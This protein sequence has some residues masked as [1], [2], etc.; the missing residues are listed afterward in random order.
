MFFPN[1]EH[2]EFCWNLENDRKMLK[3]S[4]TSHDNLEIKNEKKTNRTCKHNKIWV[5]TNSYKIYFNH[6]LSTTI[7][8]YNTVNTLLEMA[9]FYNCTE[10]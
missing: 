2:D 5:E 6:A 4:K 9:N 10:R 1:N 7:K 8:S 3:L